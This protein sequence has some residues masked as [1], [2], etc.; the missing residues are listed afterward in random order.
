[1][2]DRASSR[3][4][5]K[6]GSLLLSLL[7]AAAIASAADDCTSCHE[8]GQKLAKSAHA[9]LSCDTCHESHDKY[10]H[11]PNIAKPACITCHTDQ[12]ADYSKSAHGQARKGGNEGAPDCAL[13]HGSAHELLTPKS[14]AFRKAVPDTCGMCHSEVVEQFRGS[15]HGKALARGVV[16][17]PLCTDCHGEPK[18]L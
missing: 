2:T 18:I 17:A 15:V 1:M 7:A 10:P 12:A 6:L 5:V 3:T 16:Q 13:C 14:E 8:Q 9:S 11:P 4:A